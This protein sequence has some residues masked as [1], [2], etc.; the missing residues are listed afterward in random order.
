MPLAIVR[1]NSA[2]RPTKESRPP[3]TRRWGLFDTHLPARR[4][5]SQTLIS[6]GFQALCELSD[7]VASVSPQPRH[8][9]LPRN[10][11][12]AWGFS[13]RSHDEGVVEN[14]GISATIHSRYSVLQWGHDEGVVKDSDPRKSALPRPC[15]SGG[16]PAKRSACADGFDLIELPETLEALIAQ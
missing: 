10:Q 14:G 2:S 11:R 4:S 1:K 3:P 6:P 7:P 5:S 15:C 12:R 16:S 9:I 8:A 13:S